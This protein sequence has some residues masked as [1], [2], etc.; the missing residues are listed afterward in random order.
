MSLN[1]I[2]INKT[3]R[4]VHAD[5]LDK[6]ITE[7]LKTKNY[8]SQ[9]FV[10]KGYDCIFEEGWKFT[11]YQLIFISPWAPD[12][13]NITT[14]DIED[15]TTSEILNWMCMEGKINPGEYLINCGQ[16]EY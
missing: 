6:I 15:L 14:E 9:H 3:V 1:Q 7:F 5:K 2:G 16:Y 13:E 11:S 4:E 10:K 12:M 8:T